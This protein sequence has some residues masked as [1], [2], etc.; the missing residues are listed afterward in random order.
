[1]YTYIYIY[2]YIYMYIYIYIYKLCMSCI[3]KSIYIS[4]TRHLLLNE[5]YF[6]FFQRLKEGLEETE[7]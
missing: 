7:I 5:L 1:M 3:K 2:I 4:I 6:G